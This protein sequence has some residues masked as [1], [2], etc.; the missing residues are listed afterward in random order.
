[1]GMSGTTKELLAQIEAFLAETGLTPSK[2][3]VAAV[4]DGHLVANLRKGHSVTL[5]TADKV[6]AY[7]AHEP[8]NLRHG[9]APASF[10]SREAIPAKRIVLI[11]GGGI[12]AYKCLDLIRR[13]RERGIVS[14]CR[15][16]QGR[17]GIH[18][19]AVGGRPFQRARVY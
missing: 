14:A 17:P 3:G 6:R 1:M 16:D 7:M 15:D 18:C 11:I 19:A 9:V 12:A 8:K 5:K 13:L 2:F 4:N 10:V